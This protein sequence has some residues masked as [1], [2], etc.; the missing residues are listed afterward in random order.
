VIVGSSVCKIHPVRTWWC[1]KP[2]RFFIVT[3]ANQI[4]NVQ[5]STWS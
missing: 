5:H 2:W 1:G 3:G 4:Q